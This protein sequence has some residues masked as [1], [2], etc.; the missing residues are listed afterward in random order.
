MPTIELTTTIHAPIDRCFD[1][2]RSIDLH[3]ASTKETKEQ[4][5]AGVT[6][7]LIGKDEMVQ[8]KA[9]HF[10]ITQTL[11]SRITQFQR[12]YHFRDEMTQ[13]A[14]K[15]IK[16]DH[17]F[18]E[19]RDT[20]IMRDEFIFESPGGIFGVIA[21][22]LILEKYLRSLLVKRNE[23]IKNVAESEQWKSFLKI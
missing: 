16:H 21:N 3:K 11:T 7:G 9:T 14:F 15:M 13:G 17:L 12:P 1:L 22:K 8:W 2:A 5:I 10:G 20:T 19:A 4:A 6:S 23:V 18:E